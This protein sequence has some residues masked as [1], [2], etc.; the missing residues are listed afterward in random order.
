MLHGQ[1][2]ILEPEEPGFVAGIIYF[3]LQTGIMTAT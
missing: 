3:S 1:L 2:W